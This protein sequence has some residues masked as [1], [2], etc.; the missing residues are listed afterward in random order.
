[1]KLNR[2]RTV[3]AAV[4]AGAVIAMGALTAMLPATQAHA[5]QVFPQHF[6]GPVDT[7]IDNPPANLGIPTSAAPTN[8]A[9]NAT[10]SPGTVVATGG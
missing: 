1:M 4:G 8:G 9:L 2:I 7:T 6:G 3:S 10:N 5:E